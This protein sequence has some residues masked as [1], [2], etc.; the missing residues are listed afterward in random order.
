[1]NTFNFYSFKVADYRRKNLFANGRL[2]GVRTSMWRTSGD[3][4]EEVPLVEDDVEEVDELSGIEEEKGKDTAEKEQ[5]GAVLKHD[6]AG[7][8]IQRHRGRGTSWRKVK[9]YI[10]IATGIA[11]GIAARTAT[12]TA[13]RTAIR[14]T[15]NTVL[16]T[17][18]RTITIRII[19]ALIITITIAITI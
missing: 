2:T 12:R 5:H 14:A 17:V 4:P 18:I 15:T 9:Q 16:R 7:E 11:T 3:K 10:G 13:L 6:E 19:T 8:D 1:M